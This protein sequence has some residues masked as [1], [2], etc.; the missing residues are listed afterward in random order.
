MATNSTIGRIQEFYPDQETITAYLERFDLFVTV[1]SIE[2]EKKV[3]TLLLVIGS[4]H[5]SL[6][7]GLVSP[8]KPEDKTLEELTAILKKHYDPEPIVIAERF[9]FY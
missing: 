5:Y 8:S 2:G 9:V 7:R 6:I 1:N 3:K 4:K